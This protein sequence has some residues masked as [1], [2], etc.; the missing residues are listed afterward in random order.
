MITNQKAKELIQETIENLLTGHDNLFHA[1]SEIK[2]TGLRIDLDIIKQEIDT[3]RE[4][5]EDIV[6]PAADDLPT[7]LPIIGLVT[8]EEMYRF[9]TDD[10]SVV[11][12]SANH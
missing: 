7:E 4:K 11:F 1:I 10:K 2:N 3:V 12:S 9:T 8:Q 6:Y 5:L